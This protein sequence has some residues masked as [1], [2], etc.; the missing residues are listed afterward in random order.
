MALLVYINDIILA[1]NDSN[2]IY[3]FTQLLNTKFRLKDLGPMKYF[4]GLEIAR[5]SKRISICQRKY[6]LDILQD[7]GI[8]AAKP[9]K[10]PMET[11][12]KLSQDAGALIADPTVYRLL[13]GHLIYL[14]ITRPDVA[15]FVQLLSQY[16]DKPCQPHLDVAYRVLRYKN[17][18][19]AKA[20]FFSP[21]SSN[22]QLKAFCDSAWAGCSNFRRSTTGFWVFFGESLISWK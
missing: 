21:L 2:A 3:D 17:M 6:A 22:Y 13:I 4:L 9:T 5:I 14:T 10:F 15:Y 18:L 8:L 1:S 12:L 19:L 16:M 7:Y 11:N 20:F